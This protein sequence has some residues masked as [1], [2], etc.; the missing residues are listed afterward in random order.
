MDDLYFGSPTITSSK[1][2]NK[3]FFLIWR[4]KYIQS[5]IKSKRFKN[6]FIYIKNI[7]YLRQNLNH[8]SQLP[9]YSIPIVYQI[10]DKETFEVFRKESTRHLITHLYLDC[11]LLQV[12]DEYI[13]NEKKSSNIPHCPD[14][15]GLVNTKSPGANDRAID[16][17]VLEYGLVRETPIVSTNTRHLSIHNSLLEITN[18]PQNLK[19]LVIRYSDKFNQHLPIV[20]SLPTALRYLYFQE[21]FDTCLS[22]IKGLSSSSITHLE[23][24]FSFSKPLINLPKNLVYLNIG[25][26]F[27]N[28]PIQNCPST[29]ETL[30]LGRYNYPLDQSTFPNSLVY[31]E[32][33]EEFNQPLIQ[34]KFPK[35]L[36]YLN[37][38]DSFNQPIGPNQLPNGLKTF[39]IHNRMYSFNIF[40]VLPRDIVVLKSSFKKPLYNWSGIPENL[41]KLKIG[42]NM[43]STLS[44]CKSLVSLRITNVMLESIPSGLFPL[45]LIELQ[46]SSKTFCSGD[47]PPNVRVCKLNIG[48]KEYTLGPSIIPPSVTDLTLETSN[49]I[50]QDT[51]PN[52]VS[53]LFIKYKSKLGS[54]TPT[55]NIIPLSV[56]KCK[57]Y[58]ELSTDVTKVP[59]PSSV[60]QLEYLFME[61]DTRFP[62]GHLPKNLKNLTFAADSKKYKNEFKLESID[63]D[64]SIF[65]NTLETIDL[66][67]HWD[68]S[69][70]IYYIIDKKLFKESSNDYKPKIFYFNKLIKD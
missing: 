50:E 56:E 30:I 44:I 4:D 27:T 2:T 39:I 12:Y 43:P 59:I 38:G 29:L 3:L 25:V 14:L 41:V 64:A 6:N 8:L 11:T 51:I 23:F 7:V 21:Y 48:G 69:R 33:R 26:S 32:F 15:Y 22:N 52:S 68:V 9:L 36:K 18:L 13:E 57:L 65:P 1:T 58:F 67:P 61:D 20:E 60:V 28:V 16:V 62:L 31:L 46:V 35:S 55:R 34:G 10:K 47:I 53:T 70:E 63:F 42:A 17:K 19:S 66:T 40:D 45:G 24:G 37:L 54:K 49:Q 5:V